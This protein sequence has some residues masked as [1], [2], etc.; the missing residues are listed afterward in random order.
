MSKVNY[1]NGV[2]VLD[3]ELPSGNTISVKPNAAGTLLWGGVNDFH[4]GMKV[5]GVKSVL[6]V[7][8]VKVDTIMIDP[9]ITNIV[10]IVPRPI[11]SAD[12]NG[13]NSYFDAVNLIQERLL[14]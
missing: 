8:D 1:T 9:S 10:T 2:L 14:P 13:F 3:G 6:I 7:G 5:T 11:T 12:Q 4:Y